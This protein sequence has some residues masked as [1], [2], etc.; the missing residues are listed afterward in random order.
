MIL[1]NEWFPNPAGADAKGEWIELW[2]NSKS[3]VGLSGW[4]LTPDGKKTFTLKGT[5]SPGAYLV[6][7]RA[8]SKL[9]LKNTDGALALYDASGR[10]EDRA[11]FRGTAPEGESANRTQTG[12]FFGKATPGAVNAVPRATAL[13]HDNEYP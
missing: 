10:L 13:A 5:I 6:V 9:A 4:R 2:N 7:P 12:S 3:P 8:L 11:S 1:I